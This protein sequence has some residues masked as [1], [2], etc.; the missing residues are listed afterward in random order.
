MP[1]FNDRLGDFFDVQM[2]ANWSVTFWYTDD[3]ADP[4]IERQQVTITRDDLLLN[5]DEQF[6]IDVAVMYL[7]RFGI[8]S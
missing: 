5:A 7:E 3:R 4:P 8:P 6:F 1:R 2:G